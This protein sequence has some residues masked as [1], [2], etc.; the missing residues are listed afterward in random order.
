MPSLRS[1]NS[2]HNH[3]VL[4][5]WTRISRGFEKEEGQTSTAVGWCR[6][7]HRPFWQIEKQEQSKKVVSWAGLPQRPSWDCQH[8]ML[9]LKH[10]A[11]L[12]KPDYILG[13]RSC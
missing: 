5:L 4:E 1:R 11:V 2:M 13:V 6:G 12:L 8:L 3:R 7:T 9:Y 10:K